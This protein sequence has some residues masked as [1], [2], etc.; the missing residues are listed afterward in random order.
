MSALALSTEHDWTFKAT[1]L[2]IT[3]DRLDPLAVYDGTGELCGF[4]PGKKLRARYVSHRVTRP[5]VIYVWS[6]VP[7]GKFDL[8]ETQGLPLDLAKAPPPKGS[9]T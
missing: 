4:E 8:F 1:G 3:Y 6:P 5:Y 9:R 2:E 7:G